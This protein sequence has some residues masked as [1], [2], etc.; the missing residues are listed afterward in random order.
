[1]IKQNRMI[2]D[3]I[4]NHLKDI[5]IEAIFLDFHNYLSSSNITLYQ[6]LRRQNLKVSFNKNMSKII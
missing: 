6:K 5:D 1:M 2:I 4:M 3:N